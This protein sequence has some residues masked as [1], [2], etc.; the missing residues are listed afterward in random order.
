M[1]THELTVDGVRQVYHVAGRGPLCVAHSGGPGIDWAYLRMPRLEEHFTM[2]YLEPVGTGGS[3]RLDG[4][5]LTTYVRF[6]AAVV[7]QLQAPRVYL[8]GHSHGGFVVQRYAL[9]HPDRIAGLI[10][11]DTSP[12]TGP[13]FWAS[14]MAGVAAYA[15][16]APEV[17]A[18][19]QRAV[20]AADDETMT[21]ALREA[22]PIYFADFPGRR[23]EFAAF[24][25]GIRAWVVPQDAEPFDVR[26][27]LGEI[28]VP[29]VVIAGV[30]DFICR[31]R[32]A[33]ML[34]AGI[35]GSRLVELAS[36][37]HFG[38]LEQPA[39]FARAALSVR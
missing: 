11:Y 38:H 16:V 25:A 10:L 3:G 21:A 9:D 24:V 39:E 29:V 33:A 26:P 23:S 30:H 36:S 28:A 18:A 4:Y 2:V 27:R 37:G 8:L 6:L 13:E 1:N 35:P 20:T 17:P 14:A 31:P 32:W 22:V 34:H 5:G 7:D 15:A 19:F 12:V